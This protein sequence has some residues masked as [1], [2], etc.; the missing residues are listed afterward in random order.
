MILPKNANK[1]KED[2][3]KDILEYMDSIC[4]DQKE[5]ITLSF[6]ALKEKLNKIDNFTSV[7][8][9]ATVYGIIYDKA[10]KAKE[11]KIKQDELAFKKSADK[12]TLNKLDEL[13]E[14]QKNAYMDR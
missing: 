9:I 12:D 14:A 2:N 11:L 1:K 10:I 8:D 5:I 6:K 4:E 7:K 3:S 13:L